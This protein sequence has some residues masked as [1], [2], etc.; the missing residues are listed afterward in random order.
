MEG[1][2]A[3]GKGDEEGG[4]IVCE[5]WEGKI[6]KEKRNELRGEIRKDLWTRRGG[7]RRVKKG[8]KS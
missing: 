7:V 2:R 5:D 1:A 8:W 6:L 4:T 3:E